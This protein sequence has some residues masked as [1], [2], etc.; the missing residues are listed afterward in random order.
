MNIFEK[1]ESGVRS[2]CR[3]L[4]VVLARGRGYH[5]FDEEGKSYIDFFSAAGSLNYGHNP[6]EAVA[7]VSNYLADD[8]IV[9]T[10]DLYSTAKREFLAAFEQSILRPRG[11]DYVVQFTGPTGANAVEAALKVARLKTGRSNV[12]AFTNGYHGVSLGALAATGNRGKRDGAGQTLNNVARIPFE[13]YVDGI[14][15]LDLLE[16]MLEDP[17]SGLDCPAAVIFE[18]IQA[19]GGINVASTGWLQRL[20]RIARAHEILLIADEIQTGCGRTGTFFSFEPSGIVP[21][22]VTV[23]KSIGG[24]GMPMALVLMARNVDVW[25]AGQHNGTFRGNNLAFVAARAMIDKHWRDRRFA[26]ALALKIELF[27]DLLIA[28]ASKHAKHGCEARGRGMMRGLKFDDPEFATRVQAVALSLGLLIETC[29]PKDEVVKLLPP[30]IID[31]A[32]IA[33]GMAMLDK[34][35]T[36]AAAAPERTSPLQAAF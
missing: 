35:I 1:I 25:G 34:A 9:T 4:P 18:A 11:L 12:V 32:G 17:S 36:T 10:L 22:I 33:R 8:G 6:P 14:D 13:G 21:D 15:G 26:D 16:R 19:E 31:D 3:S 7:A 29:G 24:M 5:V 2:Y 20:E 23:S 28:V 27:D 30:L